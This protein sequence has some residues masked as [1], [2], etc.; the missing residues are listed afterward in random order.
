MN[1][2]RKHKDIFQV[3][4]T[5]TQ[6]NN[7]GFELLR[8][9]SISFDDSFLQN[10]NVMSFN[11]LADAQCE[12]FYHPNIDWDNLVLLNN[13]AYYD[14]TKIIKEDLD[15]LGVNVQFEPKIMTP[16]ELKNTMFDRVINLG[17]RFN[18]S[19]QLNDIISFKIINMWT[20]NLDEIAL[21]LM[22]N[23]R[24]RI[25]KTKKK[26]GIIVLIGITDM[27]MAYEIRLIT[28]IFDQYYK[29]VNKYNIQDK[30]LLE[31][32][33]KKISKQQKDIDSSITIR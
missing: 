5:P 6:L 17:S 3:L 27:S 1:R 20:K 11:T 26:E 10:Y 19:Y 4:I 32:N 33:Y 7:V 15:I 13:N 25:K 28:T 30:L 12:A 16:L 31:T 18:L 23:A 24:L 8:G 9:D 2:I 29:W 14:I 22:K 21:K